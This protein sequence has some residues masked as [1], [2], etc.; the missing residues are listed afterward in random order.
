MKKIF[1]IITATLISL[2]AYAD[3]STVCAD[4]E[5]SIDGS[6][7]I[8]ASVKYEDIFDDSAP[9]ETLR[10]INIGNE[11]QKI[12][13]YINL[14]AQNK[15]PAIADATNYSVYMIP[16]L[17]CATARLKQDDRTKQPIECKMEDWLKT[18]K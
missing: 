10:A 11:W 2:T 17:S 4:I 18:K 15:C 14:M 16:A 1:L 6:L 9:R 3:T 13:I 5:K 12:N 8:I 7:K